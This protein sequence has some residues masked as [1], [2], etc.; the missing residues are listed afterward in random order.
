MT[1]PMDVDESGVS[2]CEAQEGGSDT[3]PQEE[4]DPAVLSA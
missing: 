1:E 3:Q 2:P 4:G